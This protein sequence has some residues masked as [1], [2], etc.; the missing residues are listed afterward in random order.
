MP[1]EKVRSRLARVARLGCTRDSIVESAGRVSSRV[2][3][4]EGEIEM[5]EE[6]FLISKILILKFLST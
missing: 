1:I 2:E 4:I 6:I 5:I 3:R